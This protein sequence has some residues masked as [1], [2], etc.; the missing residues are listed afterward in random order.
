MPLGLS[1][2]SV[3]TAFGCRVNPSIC[4]QSASCPDPTFIYVDA[5]ALRNDRVTV[6]EKGAPHSICLMECGK[7]I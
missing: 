3:S 1:T 2:R 5:K 4:M 6:V 7:V